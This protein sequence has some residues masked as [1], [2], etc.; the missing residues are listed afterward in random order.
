MNDLPEE[1]NKSK[2]RCVD[3]I[4]QQ[5]YRNFYNNEDNEW[6]NALTALIVKITKTIQKNVVCF[7]RK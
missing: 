3:C 1:S 2:L 4:C 7:V 5:C 6:K